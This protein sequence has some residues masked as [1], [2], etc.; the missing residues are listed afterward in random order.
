MR[1][2][3]LL[4][5]GKLGLLGDDGGSK[6]EEGVH[7]CL[8]V[9]GW[10]RLRCKASASEAWQVERKDDG[11]GLTSSPGSPFYTPSTTRV[12]QTKGARVPTL[13]TAHAVSSRARPRLWPAATRKPSFAWRPDAI[14]GRR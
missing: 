10:R 4:V 11:V 2:L 14:A 3:A 1:V 9:V 13:T 6:A 8:G 12:A 7:Y 5:L